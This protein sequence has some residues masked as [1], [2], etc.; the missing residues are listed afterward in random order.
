ME[1]IEGDIQAEI[2]AAVERFESTRDVDP[3]DCFEYLYAE[4]PPELVEQ[5]EEFKA[6][7]TREGVGGGH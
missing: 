5:R 3:L 1:E 4:L 2:A 7:L 6:A